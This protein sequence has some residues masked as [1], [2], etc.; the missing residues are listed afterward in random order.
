MRGNSASSVPAVLLYEEGVGAQ[1]LSWEEAVQHVDCCQSSGHEGV[2][3][4]A[5]LVRS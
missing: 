2:T 5:W 4:L 1:Q 3:G